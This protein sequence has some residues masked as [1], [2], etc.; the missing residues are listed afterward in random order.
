MALHTSTFQY[1]TEVMLEFDQKSLRARTP[2]MDQDAGGRTA[3]MPRQQRQ[4]VTQLVQI[5]RQTKE[6]FFC[7]RCNRSKY[8]FL[9]I[10]KYTRVTKAFLLW[11][12]NRDRSHI[13]INNNAVWFQDDLEIT[14]ATPQRQSSHK[15]QL[16]GGT[17]VLPFSSIRS[18]VKFLLLPTGKR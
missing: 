10:I 1:T 16:A 7:L 13:P 15:C 4:W 9:M 17:T 14:P 8:H 6:S 5:A 3:P 18:V 11:S 2:P 12:F